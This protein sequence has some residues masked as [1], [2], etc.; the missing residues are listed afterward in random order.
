M[1]LFCF[2]YRLVCVISVVSRLEQ[3]YSDLNEQHEKPL[4]ATLG[5]SPMGKA[6]RNA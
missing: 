5:I 3:G 2:S 6:I 4:C 1:S